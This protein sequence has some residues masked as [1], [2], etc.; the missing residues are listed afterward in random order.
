MI[1]DMKQIIKIL[2][3]GCSKC[4]SLA[5][6]TEEVVL[7]NSI[8]ATIEKVEDIMKIMEYDV[9]T[10][11]ALVVNERL[12]CQGKVPSK[13]EVLKIILIENE[14]K[15]NKASDCCSDSDDCC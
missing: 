4:K 12:V 11:P 2:G 5:K 15:D 10:T 13:N 8:N 1:C 7:E 14:I 9:I 6:L 3:T